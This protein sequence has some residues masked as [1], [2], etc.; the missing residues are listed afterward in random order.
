MNEFASEYATSIPEQVLK[1]DVSNPRGAV[2]ALQDN[3]SYIQVGYGRTIGDAITN[4]MVKTGAW[5]PGAS[6]EYLRAMGYL[7]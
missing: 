1:V 6:E 4:L 2:V 3:H 7:A 5:S